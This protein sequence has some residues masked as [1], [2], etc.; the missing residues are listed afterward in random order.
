MYGR[1]LLRWSMAAFDDLRQMQRSGRYDV[2]HGGSILPDQSGSTARHSIT[3][4]ACRLTNDSGI[5]S[6]I[7]F[8]VLRL[9]IPA[10]RGQRSGDCGQFLM[11]V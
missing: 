7:A 1:A 4:S 3:S 6:P 11:S 5:V 10:H 8:A 2:E 9:Q